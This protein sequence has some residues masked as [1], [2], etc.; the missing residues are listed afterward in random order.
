MLRG[1]AKQERQTSKPVVVISF[2]KTM[3]MLSSF[4]QHEIREERERER[5]KERFS[6]VVAREEMNF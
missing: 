3:T 4:L 2:E 6:L 5:E 1:T